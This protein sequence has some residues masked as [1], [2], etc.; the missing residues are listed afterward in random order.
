M[1]SKTQLQSKIKELESELQAF[2]EQLNNYK[3]VTLETAVLGDVLEDGSIVLKKENG[4]ALLVAPAS[5]EVECQWSKEFA[6]VF[7]KLQEEGFN[8]SQW[9][10]PTKEQL[11]LAYNYIPSHFSTTFYWSST[12]FNATDAC[13]FLYTNGSV[14][15]SPKASKFFVRAF[16]CVT[17]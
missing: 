3:E 11:E 9:F 15:C 17:Y 5:T 10:I 1:T 13:G 4:L 14:G 7:Q 8:S 16:R 12:V 2:K 6:E